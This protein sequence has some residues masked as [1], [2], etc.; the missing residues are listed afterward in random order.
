MSSTTSGFHHALL[1]PVIIHVLRA[2]GFHSARPSVVDTLADIAARY[3]ILLAST[4]ADYAQLNHWTVE[5]DAT[6]VRMALHDCGVLIP[7]LTGTEEAW[8]EAL[9]KPI[10]QF[11]ERNGVR[12]RMQ[13]ERDEE[14]TADVRAFID[15][16]TGKQ[17]AEIRRIAGLLPDGDRPAGSEPE[18]RVDFLKALMKK[19]SKT[20]EESR[21]QG[22]WLGIPAEDRPVKIEG[23]PVETV[24]EWNEKIGMQSASS[25]PTPEAQDGDAAEAEV[26]VEQ[27]VVMAD[28]AE[29]DPASSGTMVGD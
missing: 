23:G 22:T 11:T 6:D 7:S 18:E 19:H 9:R 13:Q 26:K 8:K 25:L 20:G 15:W 24:K 5:P 27:D 10:E 14:D 29:S 16:V 2:A 3:L 21:F 4:T 28:A 12:Q 17:N 1:R